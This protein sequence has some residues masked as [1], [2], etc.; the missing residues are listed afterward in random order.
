MQEALEVT[1]R[2][3]DSHFWFRGFRRF[4]LPLLDAAASGRPDLRLLDCG[5]GTG[6]NLRLLER[7]GRAYGFDLTPSALAY[8]RSLGARAVRAEI[9]AIPFRS[10]SFDI[11]TSF[12]VMQ[13]AH[14]DQ[15]AMIEL[16]RL[17][18][19]GGTLIIT[20]AAMPILRGGH[21]AFWPEVR[22]YDRARMMR[23]ATG[24][25]LQ[26]ERVRYLF[27]S[28]FP[29]LLAARIASR[30]RTAAALDGNDWEMQ[31]P[32]APVNQALTWL[33]RM[34]AWLSRSM[35]MPF[36]SSVLLVATKR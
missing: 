7:Y 20:A 26:V 15:A 17:L 29:M 1:R 27:W 9:G 13:Y 32:V 34:E 14:D 25:G 12:D 3:E 4:I 21:A 22:R 36:G 35:S 33:L 16:A 28:L 2:V 31:V 8:A 18:K 19:G 11:V 24:A 30:W 6:Y 10:A 5:C 23:I